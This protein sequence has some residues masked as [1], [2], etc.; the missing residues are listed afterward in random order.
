MRMLKLI[1]LLFWTLSCKDSDIDAETY[2]F[3]ESDP[4]RN[5]EKVSINQGLWGDVWFWSGD[6]MPIGRGEICQVKREILIYE[7]T[8]IEKVEQIGFTPFYSDINSPLIATTT[9]GNDGF[10]Q[11]ELP[12]GMYSVFVKEGDNYYSNLFNS[13]GI[14]PVTIETD[15][16]A[17]IRFD[18]TYEATF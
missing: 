15:A 4:P 8:T 18:I 14:F 1:I 12:E 16:V 10:F 13:A 9:S 17:E 6:F 2:C 3:A 5:N 11:I 7:L